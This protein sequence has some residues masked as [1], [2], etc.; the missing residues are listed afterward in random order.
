MP[1]SLTKKGPP[2]RPAGG[3]KR[4]QN[5][6]TIAGKFEARSTKFET[7]SNFKSPKFKTL[8]PSVLKIR[9]S[10]FEFILR[11][12]QRRNNQQI[13]KKN[14]ILPPDPATVQPHP[15][16]PSPP[17][18]VHSSSGQEAVVTVPRDSKDPAVQSPAATDAITSSST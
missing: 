10:N 6:T 8:P 1:D 2:A 5:R 13:K 11:H 9:I 3:V 16:P 17:P 4:A 18:P 12:C 14:D 15:P 7:N